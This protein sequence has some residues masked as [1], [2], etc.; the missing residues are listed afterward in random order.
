MTELTQRRSEYVSVGAAALL[1]IP[2]ALGSASC[3]QPTS[4]RTRDATHEVAGPMVSAVTPTSAKVWVRVEPAAEV[5]IEYG[6]DGEFDDVPA[7]TKSLVTETGH[8][9]TGTID[10]TGHLPNTTYFYRIVID[11][12]P[13]KARAELKTFPV[14]ADSVKIALLTDLLGKKDVP[15]FVPLAGE[16]PDFVIVLGDWGHRK[17]SR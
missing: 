5:Q 6:I 1:C 16:D 13:V 10:Q 9:Y 4:D 15:A 12:E 8:D 17:H 2:V 3:R 14:K 11:G 7:V